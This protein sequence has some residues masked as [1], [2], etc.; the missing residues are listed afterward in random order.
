M[1]ETAAAVVQ[2]PRLIILSTHPIQYYAPLYQCLSDRG[3]VDIKVIYLSDAGAV[4]HDDPSFSGTVKWDVP[5]LEEY[6]FIVLQPGSA[7]TS[8]RFW[9]RHDDRLASV[10]ER[11]RPDWLLLYGYAS[12]MNWSALRW[13][14]SSKVEVIYTSDSNI[15]DPKRRY[16][17]PLKRLAVGYFFRQVNTFLATSEANSEYLLKFGADRRSIV[18]T[19]FAIDVQRFR[20]DPAFPIGKPRKYDFVWAGKFV[21]TKRAA[22]FVHALHLVASRRERSVTACIVGDGPCR[23]DLE[24]LV[25]ALPRN[26]SVDFVGFINQQQMPAVLGNAETLA[27]TSERE[28]Y[29]LIATEAAAAGLALIV[30]DNIGCVGATVL[31]RP[32]ANTL[33]FTV[34]NVS[35]LAKAMERMLD[36]VNLRLS[37]Q[38]ASADIALTH[39]LSNAARV[40]E[41]VVIR[42]SGRKEAQRQC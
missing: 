14:R 3:V 25:S 7:I 4:A 28:P 6:E 24:T 9:S 26:C 41:E 38:R 20:R 1:T 12:R 8:R 13:A 33:T 11:E 40:I 23:S 30:A 5:L 29:G 37:M 2:K 34:R 36:D 17:S 35:E 22:D 19:P 27:F 32:G 18:R 31:A 10:L 15:R 21:K 39:D 42:G 16:L